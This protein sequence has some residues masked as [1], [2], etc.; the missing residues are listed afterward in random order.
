MDSHGGSNIEV[1]SHT[2]S[3]GFG[4]GAPVLADDNKA[5]TTLGYSNGPGAAWMKVSSEDYTGRPDPQNVSAQVLNSSAYLQLSTVPL[6]YE[7]GG[8]THG[9]QDVGI[10]AT[11]IS[12]V[13]GVSWGY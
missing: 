11:G 7:K 10:W 12:A 13:M 9:G 6:N 1:D 2:L 3:D 4:I 8:E 5:Y